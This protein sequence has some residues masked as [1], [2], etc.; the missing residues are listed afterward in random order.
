MIDRIPVGRLGEVEEF[1]NLS[2]Y[3]VSDYANWMTGT[4]CVFHN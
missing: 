4:V 2:T 3:V 1:A